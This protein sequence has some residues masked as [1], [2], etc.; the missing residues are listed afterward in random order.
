MRNL[1]VLLAGAIL[2]FVASDIA[3]QWRVDPKPVLDIGAERGGDEYL[4]SQ[5]R[6]IARMSNGGILVADLQ[7][8]DVRLFD[9]TG[10]FVARIGRRGQ[11]PGEFQFPFWV[12]VG[13]ADTI[14]VYDYAEGPGSLLQFTSTGKFVRKAFV[15]AM[16]DAAGAQPVKLLSNGSLLLNGSVPSS[17]PRGKP[18]PYRGENGLIR[19]RYP[20]S[21]SKVMR[22]PGQVIE[23]GQQPW[24]VDGQIAAT[25]S[26]LYVG[27]GETSIISVYALDGRL[28][29]RDT[30]KITRRTLTAA[31]KAGYVERLRELATAN[32][33]SKASI[34][35]QIEQ[36]TYP[37]TFP[38]Y[39]EL[40]ADNLGYLW[41]ALSNGLG[42][43]RRGNDYLV[44]NAALKQ[45]S[46]VALPDDLRV[47]EIGRDYVLGVRPDADGVPHILLY[48]LRR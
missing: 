29:R 3:A 28:M 17:Y 22:I 23:T 46:R 24:L 8:R 2:S 19:F 9:S 30:L 4:L 38:A 1:R 32:P 44:F 13:R 7:M 42:T 37:T 10:K 5:V 20:D 33:S 6:S 15:T 11:G 27:D 14:H 18:R 26:V 21:I 12:G 41:L 16:E 31:D 45:V 25:D 48:R 35:R 40:L 47:M 34:E 39:R 36:T 43:N